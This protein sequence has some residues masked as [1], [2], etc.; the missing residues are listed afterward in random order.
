M[1]K[2]DASYDFAC[3]AGA[4][5]AVDLGK[6]FP[7]APD[8]VLAEAAWHAFKD[9]EASED[10]K[11]VSLNYMADVTRIMRDLRERVSAA[12]STARIY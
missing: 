9:R 11:F 4:P 7:K 10:A 3:G 2:P 1:A 6:E 5:L 12:L 8:E